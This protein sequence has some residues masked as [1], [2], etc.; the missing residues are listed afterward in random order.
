M[1]LFLIVGD[2]NKIYFCVFS[3]IDLNYFVNPNEALGI[4]ERDEIVVFKFL[5]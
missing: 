3:V 1:Y 2:T 4:D 5:A